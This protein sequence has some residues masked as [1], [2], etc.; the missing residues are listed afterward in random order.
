MAILKN[1]FGKSE[2]LPMLAPLFRSVVESKKGRTKELYQQTLRKVERFQ[3]DFERFPIDGV[4]VEWLNAFEAWMAQTM[5]SRNSRNVHLRNVRTVYYVALDDELVTRN[6]FRRFKIRPEATR[7]RS[8]TITQLR[9]LAAIDLPEWQAKYRDAFLLIFMLRG[10]NLV[11]FC[12]IKAMEGSYIRYRRSKTGALLE[13]KVEPEAL[14]I[15]RRLRGKGQLLYPLDRINDYR[16]YTARLNA[17]LQNIAAKIPGMPPI[18]SYWARHTWAS[19]AYNRCGI[20]KDVISQALGHSHGSKVTEIYLDRDNRIVHKA[21]RK[22]IKYVFGD[23]G[24]EE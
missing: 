2:Q 22:V 8:L 12:H 17:N 1:L 7:K 6:P 10:I 20:S 15:I 3:A 11:D 4:T 21:N 16:Q 9:K 24:S 13:V 23:Y 18:T 19:I 5:P 14:A